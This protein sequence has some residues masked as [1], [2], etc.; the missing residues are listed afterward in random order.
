MY[1]NHFITWQD[2]SAD[3]FT[4]VADSCYYCL[5]VHRRSCDTS[6]CLLAPP[7]IWSVHKL[8]LWL[9]HLLM[10]TIILANTHQSM[11]T[12]SSL[13]WHYCIW[14]HLFTYLV[15]HTPCCGQWSLQYTTQNYWLLTAI[16][17]Q[18]SAR[19]MQ[20][21]HLQRN[22][23]WNA[24]LQSA[25]YRLLSIRQLI[26]S[27]LTRMLGT[28]HTVS[29]GTVLYEHSKLLLHI[30]SAHSRHGWHSLLNPIQCT[31]LPSSSSD[32]QHYLSDLGRPLAHLTPGLIFIPV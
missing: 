31:Y 32:A 12:C 25:H 27:R 5:E 2:Y 26:S 14:L 21:L 22:Y 16:R 15:R 13:Q 17:L 23:A 8:Q 10:H 24:P 1:V 19:S 28:A 6:S 9:L 29:A 11:M 18:C 7:L 4:S 30:T 3:T 20:L